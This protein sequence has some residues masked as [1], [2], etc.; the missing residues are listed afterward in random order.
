MVLMK[1]NNPYVIPRN[2]K[3]EKVINEANENN[4]MPLHEMNEILRTP[5]KKTKVAKKY[6]FQP[7]EEEK[8][9]KTFCGT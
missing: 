5:Y 3:I 9:L 8:V 1:K 7:N 6:T 2:H 4:F